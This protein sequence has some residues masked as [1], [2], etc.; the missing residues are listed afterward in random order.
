[1]HAEIAACLENVR[2]RHPII[3]NMT[4]QVVMNN[5]ANAL[6]SIGASP[7]MSSAP[8]EVQEMVTLSGALVINTG[9]LSREQLSSM[10][11]AAEKAIELGKPWVLDPVGAGA[12]S[13]RLKENQKLLALKPTAIRGNASEIMALLTGKPSGRGVDSEDSSDRTL[14][15]LQEKAAEL[16][17]VIAVTGATD[18]IASAGQLAKVENGHPMMSRVT[19]TGCTATAL[20][21]AF[22]ASN[23]C[24]WQATVASIACLG[25]AGE[26][27]AIDC[28]G[29]GSL[30]TRILD[31]L[32]QLNA[33]TITQ[34]LDATTC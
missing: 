10:S 20:T 31:K 26:L 5:T 8:E 16:D 27:A 12:T 3:H 4:N 30:Q 19:G 29:P 1:M 13:F 28:P 25:I 6:L 9:T 18:Y 34:H 17:V 23:D 33:A 22:L 21:G 11:L 2:T 14:A 24:P 32:Y 7:I 15:F